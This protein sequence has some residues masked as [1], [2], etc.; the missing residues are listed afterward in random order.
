MILNETAPLPS[1][2]FILCVHP[3]GAQGKP[4]SSLPIRSSYGSSQTPKA[5]RAKGYWTGKLVFPLCHSKGLECVLPCRGVLE[6][7]DS[8]SW[9]KP[10]P[11]L[12]IRSSLESSGET[13]LLG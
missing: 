10:L 6:A 9:G 2:S 1:Y 13:A 4:L 5:Q 8:F 7:R 3:M 11:S 12:P